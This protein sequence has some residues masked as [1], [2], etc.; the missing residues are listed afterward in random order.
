MAIADGSNAINHMPSAISHDTVSADTVSDD[1][2]LRYRANG[3][4]FTTETQ[5]SFLPLAL[6]R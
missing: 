5:I 1:Y 6:S 2:C 4:S 3:P